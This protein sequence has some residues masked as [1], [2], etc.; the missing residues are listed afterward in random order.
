MI[1]SR[2]VTPLK[3]IKRIRPCHVILQLFHPRERVTK[4]LPSHVNLDPHNVHRGLA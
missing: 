3:N 1:R 4:P 2:R